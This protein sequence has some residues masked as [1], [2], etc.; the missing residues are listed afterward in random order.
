MLA[1]MSQH[2]TNEP[3]RSTSPLA[4]EKY[5]A[6][7]T[8]RSDG[9]ARSVPVWPVD[10]GEGRIGFVTSSRTWKVRRLGRNPE[11]RIQP[12]D[13]RG[14]VKAGTEPVPGEAR[15]VTGEDFDR[16]RARVGDKYGIQLRIINLIHALPGRRT[17]HPNDCAV[18]VTPT[19][20]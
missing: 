12:S 13:S 11:V 18:I 16:I 14:R 7:T 17:G 19:T 2:S 6:F 10:A 5:I 20:S 9:T 8:Y 4:A 1:F 15:V 3:D